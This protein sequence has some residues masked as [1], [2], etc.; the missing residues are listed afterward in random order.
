MAYQQN[1][2]VS[3]QP[4]PTM[5]M[6]ASGGNR[7]ALNRPL[8][9]NGKR[10]WSHGLC[11]CFDECGTWCCAC[12]CPCVVHGK[13][14]QRLRHLT[15]KGTPDPTGG[16]CCS[17]ACW[18][19]CMLNVVAGLGCILACMNRGDARSRYNIDGGCCGD[20]CASWCCHSCDL[21]QV[22]RE[23]ELEEKSFGQRY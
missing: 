12:W 18:G 4:M 16:D 11:G 15:D 6:Q 14:K 23:I 5:G 8:D 22:S 3:Q 2:Y 19:H 1:Q 9:S 10:G 20:C 21:T 13:N 7:N 17:G